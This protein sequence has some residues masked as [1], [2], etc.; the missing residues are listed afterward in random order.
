MFLEE[1]SIS[2]T[3]K[4]TLD[5]HMNNDL[6]VS[7]AETVQNVSVYC[8]VQYGELFKSEILH[9]DHGQHDIQDVEYDE[10]V[11]L[12]FMDFIDIGKEQIDVICD[13]TTCQSQSQFWFDQ[14]AG[15][16]TA[17]NF[18][19]VCHLRETTDKTNTV[20]LLMNYCPILHVPEQIEWGHEKEDLAAHAYY[21]KLSK[22]Y[23]DLYLSKCGL[24]I[25]QQWPYLGA[26]PD[27]I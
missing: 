16:I 4:T 2:E 22:K 13:K 7:H 18:Y 14:R 23:K 17:S 21:K 15:R 1:Q 6:N 12:K 9:G 8:M 24:V 3:N 5:E 26:S 20:K 19:K 11:I 25:N 10:T 27:R